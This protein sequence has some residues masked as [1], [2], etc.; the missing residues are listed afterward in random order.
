MLIL[1][2]LDFANVM[3]LG[4]LFIFRAPTFYESSPFHYPGYQRFFLAA[5]WFFSSTAESRRCERRSRKK[6]RGSNKDLTETGNCVWKASGIQG[7]TT[8]NSKNK[9]KEMI[10][11]KDKKKTFIF[12]VIWFDTPIYSWEF[13]H[14]QFKNILYEIILP[15]SCTLLRNECD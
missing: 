4:I 8:R 2:T 3:V 12:V 7:T 6:T 10:I 13:T 14:D 11:I 5:R 9:N 1:T 15:Q